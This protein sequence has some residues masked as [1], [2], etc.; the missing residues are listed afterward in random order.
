MTNDIA[1]KG[2]W[3]LLPHLLELLTRVGHLRGEALIARELSW[4]GR[5][6]DVATLSW[7]RCLV[8]AFELKLHSFGRVLEQAVYNQV[9]FDRSWVVVESTPID[10]NRIRAASLGIGI[11]VVSDQAAK[12]LVRARY[13]PAADELRRLIGSRIAQHGFLHVS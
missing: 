11:I 8:S 10:A 2:E 3:R 9:S 7:R 6:V 1:A 13:E 4:H 5:R 12:V